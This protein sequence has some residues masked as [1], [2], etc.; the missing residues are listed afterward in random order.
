MSCSTE[1]SPQSLDREVELRARVAISKVVEPL[2]RVLTPVI[3]EHGPVGAWDRIRH[4]AGGRFDRCAARVADLDV[5]R[6]LA[7]AERL[8]I[9]ILLPGDDEWPSGLDELACPPAC[10]WVKGSEHLAHGTVRSVAIV[11]ARSATPY[12]VQ[13]AQELGHGLASRGFTVVSGAAFGIDVAAHRG[14]IVADRPTVAAMAGGVDRPYPAAHTNLLE[15]I[16]EHGAVIS[17][18]PPGASP[19]RQRFLARNRLIAAI[20]PGTVVVEAGLRSGSLNTARH[21]EALCRVV[22]AVPGSVYSPTS[23]GCHALVRDGR[24]VLV[25]DAAECAEL[26]GEIGADLAPVQRGEVRVR[27]DLPEIPRRIFDALTVHQSTSV[28]R[29]TRSAGL[30]ASEV[31][32]GLGH[33]QLRGMAERKDNGWRRQAP[34]G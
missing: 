11:G 16:V 6:V 12:G 3:L 19:Q 23:A 1:S 14:A 27:D 22:A 33:L 34:D 24:A 2:D 29:L 32:R 10:L 20:T 28:D 9:R 15:E 25:T 8:G 4:N 17:E 31:L 26:L 5:D 13:V 7:V 21:A 18:S 30:S